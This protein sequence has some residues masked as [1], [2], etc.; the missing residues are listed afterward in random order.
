VRTVG[1]GDYP[2]VA[3]GDLAYG[4]VVWRFG[5]GVRAVILRPGSVVSSPRTLDAG[6]GSPAVAVDSS[7]RVTVAWC[8][9]K[10]VF[11]ARYRPSSTRH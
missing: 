2:A 3:I 9:D 4:A 5:P 6:S 10:G 11:V 7:G 1:R 8:T